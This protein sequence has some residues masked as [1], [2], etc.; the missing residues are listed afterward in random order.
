[1]EVLTTERSQLAANLAHAERI[2]ELF[3]QVTSRTNQVQEAANEVIE[4]VAARRRLRHRQRGRPPRPRRRC[5]PPRPKSSRPA[6]S[7]SQSARA[8]LQRKQSHGPP[9]QT[10]WPP[11]APPGERKGLGPGRVGVRPAFGGK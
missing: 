8:P 4:K 10:P 7:G 6:T 1:M 2:K 3:S 11:T 5:L 9:I